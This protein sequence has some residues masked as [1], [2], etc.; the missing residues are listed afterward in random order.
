M[1]AGAGGEYSPYSLTD[2]ARRA[3]AG[4]LHRAQNWFSDGRWAVRLTLVCVGLSL[5]F[6]FPT[7]SQI[8]NQSWAVIQQRATDLFVQERYTPLDRGYVFTFRLTFPLIG[9]F[10]GGSTLGYL[11]IQGLAGIGILYVTARLADQITHDRSSTILITAAV[12]LSY[13]GSSAFVEVRGNA[14]SLALLFLLVAMLARRWPI[15]LV[16]IL[17]AAFSD[18]RAIF[19]ASFVWL[20][21][22]IH[23]SNYSSE[24]FNMRLVT[25]SWAVIAGLAIHLLLRVWL[26]RQFHLTD[27]LFI[28]ADTYITDQF[29]NLP[30]GLWTGLEGLWIFVGVALVIL[31][32]L[33]E[34]ALLIIYLLLLLGMTVVAIS[35]IDVTRSMIYLLPAGFVGLRV[36]SKLKVDEFRTLAT[37][38]FFL[39]LAW[40][41][42]Y[43]GG[44]HSIWWQ[45][46]LLI[47]L[48]RMALGVY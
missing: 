27:P 7:Y 5:F 20:Y 26:S 30:V 23:A 47:Q 3:V 28:A 9:A 10:L 44:N 15:V 4:G 48:A 8:D 24:S 12:S 17:L 29:N 22:G 38:C 31:W 21:R 6:A 41:G 11:L 37:W 42:Y 35:V 18:E 1:R 45:Y 14:D 13:A 46:P 16:A 34:W 39:A 40:P 25:N 43:V 33:R 19:S 2:D 36:A 32:R